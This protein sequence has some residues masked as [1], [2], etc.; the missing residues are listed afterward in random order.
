MK[1]FKIGELV[2]SSITNKMGYGIV[3]DHRYS[4]F[5]DEVVKVLW[6]KKFTMNPRWMNPLTLTTVE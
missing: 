1:R 3:I 5:G 4:R 2:K 6:N